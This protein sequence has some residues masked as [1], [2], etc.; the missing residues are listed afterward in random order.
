VVLPASAAG[1]VIWLLLVV[2]VVGVPVL[3]LLADLNY[4]ELARTNAIADT[5]LRH[6]NEDP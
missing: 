5:A 3:T 1:V 4:R 6:A 2:V